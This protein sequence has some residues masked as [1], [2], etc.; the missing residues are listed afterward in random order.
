MIKTTSFPYH[1]AIVLFLLLALSLRHGDLWREAKCAV[2]HK[3][4]PSFN[5]IN[6]QIVLNSMCLLFAITEM[7]YD[8]LFFRISPFCFRRRQSITNKRRENLCYRN[9]QSPS[10]M[11]L[12]FHR[13]AFDLINEW[14]GICGVA[15]DRLIWRVRWVCKRS[16]NHQMPRQFYEWMKRKHL[17][18]RMNQ[19][20]CDSPHIN[21]TFSEGISLWKSDDIENPQMTHNLSMIKCRNEANKNFNFPH[22]RN[23]FFSALPSLWASLI[24]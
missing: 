18:L 22:I 16:M 14:V 8:L 2:C 23:N 12:V 7:H 1:I 13:N 21:M 10:Q 4:L 6:M 5:S 17:R 3:H 9:Q 20:T 15:V 11:H 19:P 24:T